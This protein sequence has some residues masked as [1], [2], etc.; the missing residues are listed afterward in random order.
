MTYTK[1][2]YK[3][4]FVPKNPE[5]YIGNSGNIIYRSSY[6]AQFMK[7][8]DVNT[9]ILHWASE[10]IVVPYVSPLD[11]HIHRYFVDFFIEVKTTENKIKKYL[12]EV[13]PYKYTLPP[14]IPKRKTRGFISEVKQWGVNTAKWEAARKFAATQNWE[15]MIITERDLGRYK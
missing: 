1:D 7:W 5:K 3:G 6:E 9:S 10:E 4:R 15:F 13:K 8:C 11:G 14:E 2:S 12:I